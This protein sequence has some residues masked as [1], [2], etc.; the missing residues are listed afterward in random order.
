MTSPQSLALFDRP[1]GSFPS[2][3]TLRLVNRNRIISPLVSP[4]TLLSLVLQR[5]TCFEINGTCKECLLQY[6]LNVL[7]QF[8]DNGA[9]Q[10]YMV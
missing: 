1:P 9:D 10:K 5:K 4:P 7:G 6:L 3:I 8:F 2:F